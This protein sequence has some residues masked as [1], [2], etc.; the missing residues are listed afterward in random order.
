MRTYLIITSLLLAASLAQA[1]QQIEWDTNNLAAISTNTYSLY[2]DITGNYT[3]GLYAT[4]AGGAWQLASPPNEWLDATKCKSASMS[5]GAYCA[6]TASTSSNVIFSVFQSDDLQ[7]WS[8]Y[9]NVPVT[10]PGN[11]TNWAFTQFSPAKGNLADY[12]ALRAIQNPNLTVT[13]LTAP[14]NSNGCAYL[15]MFSRDG[16]K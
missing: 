1:S 10:V 12:Y 11:S 16:V 9:T 2:G 3:N 15:S 8:V 7:L 4:R 5:V 6:N 14:A 13:I